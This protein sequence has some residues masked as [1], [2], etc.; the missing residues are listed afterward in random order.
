M[1]F[2]E[3]KGPDYNILLFFFL[4]TILPVQSPNISHRQ[5]Q[6]C[7]LKTRGHLSLLLAREVALEIPLRKYKT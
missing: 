5:K 4:L 7:F 2:T 3:H 1:V 6:N